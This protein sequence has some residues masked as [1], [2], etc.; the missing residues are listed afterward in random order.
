M[1]TKLLILIFIVLLGGLATVVPVDSAGIIFDW[2][3]FT[4]KVNPER[5]IFY[6]DI[7]LNKSSISREMLGHFDDVYYLLHDNLTVNYEFPKSAAQKKALDK[8]KIN[9][10]QVSSFMLSP[11]R[12]S[13][14]NKDVS[15]TD[16]T[17][18]VPSFFMN[19]ST[20]TA[21]QTL[22]LFEPQVNLGFEF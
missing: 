10:S 15:L 11:E 4:V 6:P 20:E 17:R 5:D 14:R 9:I 16:I 2:Q 22:K 8:I 19:P 3:P 18:T 13:S 21:V 12:T 7:F 1:F